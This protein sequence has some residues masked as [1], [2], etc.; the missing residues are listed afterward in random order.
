M[1]LSCL[2]ALLDRSGTVRKEHL[3]AALALWEYVEASVRTVFG[4]AT[5]DPIA[6]QIL[7]ALRASPDGLTRTEISGLFSR[8]RDARRLES[9]LVQLLAR[10]LV[11]RR[12]RQTAGRPVETWYA[13][14]PG[15]GS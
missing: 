9:V 8:H 12:M 3:L 5:G 4:D 7:L 11:E 2:Y 13:A 10:G 14:H 15:A 1:R 6:D